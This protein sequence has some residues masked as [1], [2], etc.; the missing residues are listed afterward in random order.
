MD[1]VF[2]FNIPA[3]FALTSFEKYILA[4]KRREKYLRFQV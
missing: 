1:L 2:K 4:L 3:A